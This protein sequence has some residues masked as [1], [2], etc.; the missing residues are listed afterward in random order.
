MKDLFVNFIGA[1][2]FSII[3][4]FYTKYKGKG[5]FAPNFIPSPKND[6]NDYLKQIENSSEKKN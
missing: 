3:G 4:Y 5:K 6:D 2:V 1:V